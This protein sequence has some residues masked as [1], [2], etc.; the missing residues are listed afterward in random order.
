MKQIYCYESTPNQLFE[1]NSFNF[2]T[3]VFKKL[4]FAHNVLKSVSC[5]SEKQNFSNKILFEK[6]KIEYLL[7]DFLQNV[8]I[9]DHFKQSLNHIIAKF[10]VKNF[11][12]E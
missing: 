8:D 1:T 6:K 2:S 3:I 5:S 11:I 12:R 9:F 4:V 10:E 7:D